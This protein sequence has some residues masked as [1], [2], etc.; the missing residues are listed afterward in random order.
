MTLCYILCYYLLSY[1]GIVHLSNYNSE[2]IFG[3][4]SVVIVITPYIKQI[5]PLYNISIDIL[6]YI[7]KKNNKRKVDT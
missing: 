7:D 4:S 1:S 3:I 2:I 6:Y 5:F